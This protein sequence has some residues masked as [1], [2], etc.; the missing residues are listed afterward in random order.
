MAKIVRQGTAGADT[1]NGLYFTT[2]LIGGAGNDT[3]IVDGGDEVVEKAGQGIDTVQSS[4]SHTLAANVEN[5]TLTGIEEQLR[6]RQR[7]Q[8][9][10]HGQFRPQPAH[11]NGR[12]GHARGW[13]WQRH[14]G[15]WGWQRSS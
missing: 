10:D 1:F 2:Q 11:R 12:Q 8:Q 15:R 9:F 13:R 5:L 7:P 6:D 3:Y 4:L 14:A